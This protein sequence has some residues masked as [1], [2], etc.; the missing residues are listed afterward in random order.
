MNYY[1]KKIL[2]SLFV[3]CRFPKA[4]F[5]FI[6]RIIGVIYGFTYTE[7]RDYSEIIKIKEALRAEGKSVGHAVQSK[8][9]GLFFFQYKLITL[10]I[11][12]GESLTAEHFFLNRPLNDVKQLLLICKDY[13]TISKDEIVFDPGCGAGK[14]LFYLTDWFKCIGVGVDIYTPAINVANAAN[15]DNSVRFYNHS[16]LDI[17]SDTKIVPDNCD[18]VFINSW[19]NHVYMYP[20]YHEMINQLLQSC[21]Y[22]LVINSVKFTLE[23][24]IP[25][26]DILVLEIHDNAQYALIRG[27]L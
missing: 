4:G 24:L 16:M 21:R 2:R 12:K 22:M 15:F 8:K 23:E 3:M 1:T 17:D 13:L 10:V 5:A 25:K 27:G 11:N 9:V 19:L 14:H 18:Y 26:A 7:L 20:G 6:L